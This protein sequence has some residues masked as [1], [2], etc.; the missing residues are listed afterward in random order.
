MTKITLHK[1]KTAPTFIG[2]PGL[3]IFGGKLGHNFFLTNWVKTDPKAGQNVFQKSFIFFQFLK[4][5]IFFT[6]FIGQSGSQM[7]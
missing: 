5:F 1:A 7:S 3:H 2:L 6:I 4:I